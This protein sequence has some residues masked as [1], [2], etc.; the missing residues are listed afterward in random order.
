MI[1]LSF[2]SS[3][4]SAGVAITDGERRVAESFQ[5]CGLTHSRTLLP[6]AQSLLANCGM[7]LSQIDGY[8]VAAGPGSF[9]GIR[10][11][12]ATVKGLALAA[13]RP[14]VG[15]STLEA[16]AMGANVLRAPLCCVMDARAGQVYQAFFDCLDGTMRRLGED[17]A[18]KIEA[19]AAEI[20][21]MP[22]FMV[23]DGAFLCYNECNKTCENIMLAPEAVRFQSAY[24]VA[25]AALVKF[26]EGQGVTADELEAIYLRRPQAERE[27][28]A[29]LTKETDENAKEF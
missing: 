8:A 18:V 24:G 12:V 20:G 28:L 22:Y 27:R 23:G 9:T 16:M 21:Q 2:E 5:N 15:V 3:A 29:R 4:K 26:G 6:M 17:R 14:V 1:L 10:I 7:A 13:Q 19:L 11:G 25:L